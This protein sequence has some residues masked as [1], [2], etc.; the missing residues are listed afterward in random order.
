MKTWRLT[1]YSTASNPWPD[2]EHLSHSAQKSAALREFEDWGSNCIAVLNLIEEEGFDIWAI[3]DTGDHP[4][5]T[6]YKGRI[7]ISGDAAHASSPHHG[8]GAGFCIEDSAVLAELLAAAA[9]KLKDDS[10]VGKNQLLEAAFATFEAARKERAQWL[11]QSS[12]FTGD[13]YEWR[14][15]GC[16]SNI[17][18]IQ[19]E[20][21][22][23][24]EKIW[25]YD[26]KKA[27]EEALADLRE[28]VS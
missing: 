18:K 12:R 10:N 4:P 14:A 24:N 13:L 5:R 8:A 16:G 2:T 20:V 27:V 3:F 23:R 28:R 9:I 17:E 11:V 21:I 25:N 26:L 19:E 6:Y 15:E 7:V 22:A 1:R